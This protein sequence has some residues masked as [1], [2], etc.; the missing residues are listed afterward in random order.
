[1]ATL[2][3]LPNIINLFALK[4]NYEDEW[5]DKLKL[6][7]EATIYSYLVKRFHS[8]L[9]V[10]TSA[11]SCLLTLPNDEGNDYSVSSTTHLQLQY[12]TP[13]LACANIL[14]RH[15]VDGRSTYENGP[16]VVQVTAN[17]VSLIDM[18]LGTCES[19]WLPGPGREI[20]LADI[21]PSQVC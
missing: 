8:L 5:D 17:G 2:D 19:R 10:T 18:Q 15:R 7:P 4:A 20:V 1:M 12:D 13:T 16:Y 9:L 14:T 11:S 6:P 21:S 3:G